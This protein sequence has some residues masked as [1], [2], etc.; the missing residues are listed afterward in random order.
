MKVLLPTDQGRIAPVLDVARS[1]LL[2]ELGGD[3][4]QRRQEVLV[5]GT[6]PLTRVRRLVELEAQVLICGAVSWPLEAMLGSAGLRV[7][8]NTGGP[9]DEV[10][11][12]FGAGRMTE[13]AFLLPGCPGRRL[14][15]RQR[16]GRRGRGGW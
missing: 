6:D 14:R 1:F 10:I 13:D 3:G 12:A 16:Q 8:P 15:R 7:I 4:S 5:P 11:A 2:V 9:V